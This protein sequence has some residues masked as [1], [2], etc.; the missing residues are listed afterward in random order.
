MLLAI[1]TIV[2]IVSV[3]AFAYST[4]KYAVNT[5]AGLTIRS[6]PSTGYSKIGAAC[7]GITFT[8]SKISGNWAYTDSI[9]CSNGKY[10]SGWLCLD[11]C[12]SDSGSSARATY[13][14][15]F[16]STRGSGYSLS[17]GKAVSKTS[18]SKGTSVYVWGWVH[19]KNGNLFNS[20][21]PN[22]TCNMT[23]RAKRPN[24]S[25]AFSYTYNSSDNN[26]I[27]V[28][29]DSV[30]TWTIECEATG[31]ITGIKR[32]TITCTDSSS[33]NKTVAPTNISLSKQ[34]VTINKGS[35]T[36]IAATVY[37]SNASNKS[38]TWSSSNITVATVSSKG[39]ITSKSPGKCTVYAKTSNGKSASCTVYVKGISITS[40]IP[41]L[42]VGDKMNICTKSYGTSSALTWSSSNKS[43]ASVNSSGLLT[44]KGAGS[45]TITVTTGDGYKSSIN[46]NVKGKTTKA[47]GFFAGSGPVTVRLNKGCSQGKIK[48][49]CKAG[50][51]IDFGNE[52]VV[53]LK[54]KS[55]KQIW[56]GT[57]QSGDTLKLGSD[58]SEYVVYISRKPNMNNNPIYLANTFE[59]ILTCSSNCY[60]Y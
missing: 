9:L 31:N 22:Y 57:C 36:R 33:S 56:R 60:I 27:C 45:A 11:Y 51:G 49:T 3:S 15:V 47:N 46:I 48:I 12:R 35:G 59:W 41:T 39:E 8:A 17:E 30:G 14:D 18:F 25:T 5:S 21:Y 38:V 42:Y 19:D 40:A 28:N 6:G 52:F 24:G 29:L 7:N 32:Q 55:G 43:V 50:N 34:S 1:I 44:A 2:S 23:L 16:A 37:P 20:Y 53:T 13:I 26:W 10:Y 58:Y 4:G 54:T